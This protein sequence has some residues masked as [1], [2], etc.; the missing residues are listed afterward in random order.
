MIRLALR[1]LVWVALY[2]L[3]TDLGRGIASAWRDW[4]A[5][6]PLDTATGQGRR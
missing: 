5:D 2:R 3:L 6:D 1:A 4:L